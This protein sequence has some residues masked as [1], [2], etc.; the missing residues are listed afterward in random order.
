MPDNEE[1]LRRL[2]ASYRARLSEGGGFDTVTF[3][4]RG[5][6]DAERKL[7]ALD[8]ARRRRGN[9]QKAD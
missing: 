1:E 5:I 3:C 2:I 7:L 4:L 9:K 6:E 8:E